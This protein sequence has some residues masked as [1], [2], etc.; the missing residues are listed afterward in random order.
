MPLDADDND[1]VMNITPLCGFAVVKGLNEDGE[2]CYATVAT[3]GLK[4]I[5]CLGMAEYAILRLKQ[6]LIRDIE[7]NW[8]DD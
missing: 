2:V 8:D 4:S 3:Q 1:L 6:G 7:N 5:E